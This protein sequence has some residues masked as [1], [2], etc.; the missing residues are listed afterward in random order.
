[1][2]IILIAHP[3]FLGSQSMPRFTKLLAD[4]MTKRGHQVEIW[5]PKPYFH[6]INITLLKKWLGYIDQYVIFPIQI[7]SRL[8]SED[9]GTLYVV[10]DHALGPYVPIIADKYHVIHCHDFLAQ[11][12]ALGEIPYHLTSRSG[13]LYQKFI[14]NGY[15][16]GRNFISVSEKTQSDLKR[17]MIDNS[18]RSEMVYNGVDNSYQSLSI[19]A[20]RE[21]IGSLLQKKLTD[22][23]ILHIG[24]NQWYKNR[25]G[26]I[27][28]YEQWRVRY[29]KS[30]PLLL[31]GN[32][33]NSLLQSKRE[34][35]IYKEDIH[36]MFDINDEQ[37][38]I[39]YSGASVFLFPSI[40][41]GFGWPIAEA[42]ACKTIVI[43]TEEAPMSEVA[44]EAA[45][46]IKRKPFLESEEIR[47][48]DEAA[49]TLETVLQL[50]NNEREVWIAK[51]LTNVKRFQV[52]EALN[53]IEKIY[54]QVS[55]DI[56]T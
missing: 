39:A 42:M 55:T 54:L 48:A 43:T 51:G 56:L 21:T 28:I 30:L 11:K 45:F 34:Q 20:P 33:P 12:S 2:K 13:K 36:L 50:D 52:D 15:I 9:K 24:G 31:I 4:G 37:V 27:E 38:K 46:F 47:W 7:K 29:N 23:Y 49:E 32:R 53:K 8:K 17:F 6:R 18:Y 10:T 44:G 22:G 26:V 5:R 19:T 35:S 1:M 16:K 14:R 40:A 3:L 41:E 25:V